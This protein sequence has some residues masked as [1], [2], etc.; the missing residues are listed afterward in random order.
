[1]AGRCDSPIHQPIGQQAHGSRPSSPFI[2]AGSGTS[3]P[4]NELERLKALRPNTAGGPRPEELAVFSGAQ[5]AGPVQNKAATRVEGVPSRA[6]L[7]QLHEA[8]RTLKKL[9]HHRPPLAHFL[10]AGF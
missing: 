4:A 6:V 5:T 9:S 10:P 3:I 7:Q 2:G 1:M 8:G